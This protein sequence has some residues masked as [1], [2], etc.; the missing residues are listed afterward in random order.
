M[1]DFL[2][3]YTG[4]QIDLMVSSG[5]SVSTKIIDNSLVSGSVTSTGSF[6]KVEATKLS[7]DGSGL[8]GIGAS[9]LN[10]PNLISGSQH[11]FTTITSS[12]DISS[13]TTLIANKADIKG[14]IT[15]SGAI[16][17]SS[18]ETSGTG[19]FEKILTFNNLELK[20]G[21]SAGDITVKLRSHGD[22]GRVSVFNNN[23]L[24]TQLANGNISASGNLHVTNISASGF[25]LTDSHITASG[26]ISA[27][28]TITADNYGGNVSGSVTSTGSFGRIEG[29]GLGLTGFAGTISSSLH[30]FTAITSSGG[31]S[32]SLAGTLSIGTGS[33]KN[34]LTVNGSIKDF[35]LASGSLTSTLSVGTGSIKNDLTVARVV[36]A[37]LVSGS[38]I[39]T[40]SFGKVEATKLSG[41]GSGLTNVPATPSNGTISSSLQTFSAITSS[42]DISASGTITAEQIT[43]TDDMNVTDDLIVGGTATIVGHISSSAIT[44][45]K[46]LSYDEIELR[47]ST[48]PLDTLVKIYDFQ[49]DGIVSVYQN[50]VEKIKL[51]GVDSTISSSGD[52]TINV[53]SA[54][55]RIFTSGEIS[56]SGTIIA[57]EYGGNVSGSVTSTGSFGRL[58][59]NGIGLTGFAGTISS[60]LHTFTAITSSGDISASG[61]I[62]ADNYGGNV[63]GSVT[64]TGSF[65][66]IEGNGIGLTG[67]AGTISSSLHVFTAITSSGE[68]SASGTGSF[69]NIR[70][71]GNVSASGD[72]I[73]ND[74]FLP[75][76]NSLIN[77][78]DGTN[79]RLREQND[80]LDIM[81]GG[82][83]V[84]GHITASA[85]ISASGNITG[86]DLG[87]HGDIFH[88]NEGTKIGFFGKTPTVSGSTGASTP[89]AD[90]STATA[91]VTGGF[92]NGGDASLSASLN[93][94]IHALSNL[95][96]ITGS[97]ADGVS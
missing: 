45:S 46:L 79:F 4:A 56:S 15:A 75:D 7:G 82:L 1:T 30:T 73:A 63:S 78:S 28:G 76:S 43:S 20:D 91:F 64:S 2:S 92:N 31:I 86:S 34:D 68:I 55:G 70:T 42:G 48:T 69:Q 44:S 39:S 6:G 12:G 37:S 89:R 74:L 94:V 83:E 51:S 85:N 18:I 19:S 72:L 88:F 14:D 24:V 41:D 87:V 52:L 93:S 65:G 54:S 81:D 60:S 97:F 49:D 84:L 29:D 59:G 9:S 23:V 22:K 10:V 3:K 21:S 71:S 5:S 32:G 96:L 11:V 25:I 77:F 36:D 90:I 8:T 50:A 17:A 13:S 61:T 95:G 66:R 53:I 80:N 58:E 67:F 38:L 62:T 57:K 40:G 26:D 35:S 16:S 33:I 27:S 47:D